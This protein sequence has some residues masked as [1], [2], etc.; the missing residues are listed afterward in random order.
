LADG[1]GSARHAEEGAR[2]AVASVLKLAGESFTE[3]HKLGS[4]AAEVFIRSIKAE[5]GREA[6]RTG[7]TLSDFA[8]TLLF[9]SCDGRRFIVGQLGDGMIA[10]QEGERVVPFCEPMKGEYKNETVF[11]TSPGAERFF[12]IST[13]ACDSVMSFVLM[14]DGSADSLYHRPSRSFAQAVSTL[15]TWLDNHSPADVVEAL[16][17]S[18]RDAIRNRTGDDCSIGI[19]RKVMVSAQDLAKR[20]R[21]F[22][23]AYLNRRSIVGLQNMLNT[24]TAIEALN[25]HQRRVQKIC[26]STGLS[27]TTVRKNLRF[28][29]DVCQLQFS[30][31]R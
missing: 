12:S 17:E 21:P 7:G 16:N 19:L 1:A 2:I 20:P 3:L 5:L 13:G 11:V 25:G 9:A 24:L 28:L 4:K 15:A 31:D 8:T 29:L 18:I 6:D 10:V 27:E 26:A 23:S 30:A 14:S 22:L